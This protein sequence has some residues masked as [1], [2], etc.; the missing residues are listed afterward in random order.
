MIAHK[1]PVISPPGQPDRHPPRRRVVAAHR[2]F[3][4]FRRPLIRREKRAGN[5]RS[6]VRHAAIPIPHRQ[7]HHA[8]AFRIGCKPN[9]R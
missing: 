1:R 5:D 6:L 9:C 8:R 7:L 4:R 3:N 2:R